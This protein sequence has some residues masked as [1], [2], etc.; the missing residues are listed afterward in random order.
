M[1]TIPA[2]TEFLEKNPSYNNHNIKTYSG[3]SRPQ[4]PNY[5]D[6][7]CSQQPILPT[8]LRNVQ[9]YIISLLEQE[10][11][12]ETSSNT[13]QTETQN[14]SQEQFLEQQ[15]KDLLLELK[16]DTQDEYFRRQEEKNTHT[17]EYIHSTMCKANIWCNHLQSLHNRPPDTRTHK[18]SHH[19][20]KLIFLIDSEALLKV[21]NNDTW[22]EIKEYHKLELKASTFVLSAANKS[23]LQ[24]SGN[25]KFTFIQT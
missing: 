1:F 13:E 12:D 11:T 19:F 8:R 18:F 15:F 25:G 7:K 21:L 4:S 14:V 23:K 24:S 20:W 22:N 10:Q 3:N 6:G 16:Q 9:N 17:K 5:S 2:T